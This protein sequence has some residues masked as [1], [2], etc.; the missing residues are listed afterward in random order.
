MDANKKK[1]YAI[2]YVLETMPSVVI[3]ASD[4]DA[5][6]NKFI[7]YVNSRPREFDKLF[8][9]LNDKKLLTKEKLPKVGHN[10]VIPFLVDTDIDMTELERIAKEETD[11]EKRKFRILLDGIDSGE[12]KVDST[13][14]LLRAE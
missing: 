11:E 12:I 3:E 8:S 5:A 4:E 9:I 6:L 1:L 13:D 10:G 7:E 14:I 2:F